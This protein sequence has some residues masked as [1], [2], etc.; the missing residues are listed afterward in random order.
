MTCQMAKLLLHFRVD[1]F[2]TGSFLSFCGD[3]VPSVE[4]LYEYAVTVISNFLVHV[5]VR[6]ANI[7]HCRG[8]GWL[9]VRSTV[10][11]RTGFGRFGSIMSTP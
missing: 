2:G 10:L 9:I 8:S 11:G 7:L 3:H 6:C 5:C 4:L 1:E